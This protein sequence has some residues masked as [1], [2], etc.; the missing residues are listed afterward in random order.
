M[1]NIEYAIKSLVEQSYRFNYDFDYDNMDESASFFQMAHSIMADSQKE[2]VAVSIAVSV[3]CRDSELA[4]QETRATFA[5]RPFAKVVRAVTNGGIT[6]S[7]PDL[8]DTFISIVIGAARGMLA[9]NLKG[10][11]IEGH[12]LPLIPMAEIRRVATAKG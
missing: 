8:M 5:V 1:D 7:Q 4:R 11:P 10:T 2:E 3:M 6:I 9:K 12:V